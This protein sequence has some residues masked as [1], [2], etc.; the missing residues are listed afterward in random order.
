[1]CVELIVP[2]GQEYDLSGLPERFS[3]RGEEWKTKFDTLHVRESEVL[4]GFSGGSPDS[5][6]EN[7][8]GSVVTIWNNTMPV[9]KARPRWVPW[10]TA[11]LNSL[12]TATARCRR[13]LQKKR[14]G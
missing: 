12:R 5:L 3:L 13:N 7:L 6:A 14:N 4:L 11:E 1:M 10:W 9:L 8:Q 2:F